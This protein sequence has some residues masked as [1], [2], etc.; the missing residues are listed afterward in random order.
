MTGG[1]L[2]GLVPGRI[3]KY[4]CFQKL[5]KDLRYGSKEALEDLKVRNFADYVLHNLY[6]RK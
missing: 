3:Y 1:A 5:Y 2:S 6:I 4:L